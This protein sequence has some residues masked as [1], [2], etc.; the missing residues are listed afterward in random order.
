MRQ[1]QIKVIEA[2]NLSVY[3]NIDNI[4]KVYPNPTID[5]WKISSS[6]II[7]SIELYDIVGR[8][9]FST[10]PKSQEYEINSSCLSNGVYFLIL[11]NKKVSFRLIKK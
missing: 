4:L 6:I 5:Y 1:N 8:K 3:E 11:N 9:V 10:N 7:E 2:S